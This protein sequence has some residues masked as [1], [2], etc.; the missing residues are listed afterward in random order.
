MKKWD[1]VIIVALVI[2]SF[3]P[4]GVVF[5]TNTN[6]HNSL[7]IEI[8]SKGE[9]YKR[10]PLE[11]TSENTAFTV[12]NEFGKNIVEI[13]DEKVKIV[14]ADCDDK[15]CVKSH[16]INKAGEAIICL[17][18]KV[19]VRIIGKGEQETDEQSF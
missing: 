2:I 6:K 1:V 4:E 5:I 11:K 10:L 15:I 18:H 7:Y 14:D 3:I 9:L 8:Y 17:P 12:E 19:V 16:A 13:S